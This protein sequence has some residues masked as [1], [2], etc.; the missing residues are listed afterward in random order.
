M[1]K[2]VYRGGAIVLLLTRKLLPADMQSGGLDYFFAALSVLPVL[3]RVRVLDV[4]AMFEVG[5]PNYT[6]SSFRMHTAIPG[7]RVQPEKNVFEVTIA[8]PCRSSSSRSCVRWVA[9][10]RWPR[11]TQQAVTTSVAAMREHRSPV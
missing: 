3:S 2:R 6:A 9:G 5:I 7:T 4:P 1:N 10:G 11:R 8:F